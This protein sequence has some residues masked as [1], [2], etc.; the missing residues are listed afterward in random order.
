MS[1]VLE[2]L[3]GGAAPWGRP[4]LHDIVLSLPPGCILGVLGPN[5]AGKSTLLHTLAGGLPLSGGELS[6]G[7][8]PL[9]DWD[10]LR[11]ARALSLLA[12]AA[13]LNFPFA[14]EEVVQLGRIPHQSGAATDR[15]IVTEVMAATDTRALS[16]RLYTTLSGGEKQRVQLARAM[17]QVWR[18]KDSDPR[19]LL[20]DEPTSALD[21]AHQQ[22]TLQC[23][24]SLASSG[25]AVVLVMHDFNRVAEIADQITVLD[26]GRQVITDTPQAV[27]TS[28][29]FSSVFGVSTQIETHP[30]SGRPL[31][32]LT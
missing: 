15:Q 32:I 18:S 31:V 1:P 10:R 29:M 8:K 30:V 7:G 20:L 24:R 27:L 25:C 11:R 2:I 6:L 22:L 21:P 13:P 17:A 14:V 16:G 28:A 23:I 26:G 3:S 5:G 4:L 12:Q 19:L 9:A